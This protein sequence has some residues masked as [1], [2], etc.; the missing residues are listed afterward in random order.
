MSEVGHGAVQRAASGRESSKKGLKVGSG[1]EKDYVK[2]TLRVLAEVP[3]NHLISLT[4]YPRNTPIR[5]FL[6][7]YAVCRQTTRGTKAQ[8]GGTSQGTKDQ[9]P[10]KSLSA[11]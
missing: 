11:Q 3:L 1:N 2:M 9:Y 10:G 6:I 8:V 5:E 7:F 4:I